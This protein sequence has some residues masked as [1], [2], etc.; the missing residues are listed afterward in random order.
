MAAHT[1]HTTHHTPQPLA[2]KSLAPIL[3]FAYNRPIHTKQTL[4]ALIQN[5]LAKESHLIIYSDAPKTSNHK[6][7]VQQV[8]RYL[9]DIQAQNTAKSLFLDITIIE[10]PYNFGLADSIIDGVSQVMRDFGK[11]IILEDDIVV[12][13]VFLD[14]MNASLERYSDNPKV[15]SI[16][17][18]G[19]PIDSS[20][21]G[22][23]Y[24]WRCPH[25]WGWASWSDRWQYFKRD[26][27]WVFDNFNAHDI[28]YINFDGVG[29]YWNDFLLNA[30]G[31]IK[32]WA[33]FNYLIAYKHNALTLT[34]NISYVKQI[35]FDGSG[36][37]CGEEG[38]V[39]NTPYINTKFPISYPD[40]I[41]ESTLALERVQ[42]FTKHL[43]K[44]FHIRVKNKLFRSLKALTG[45]GQA[46][47]ESSLEN[48]AFALNPKPTQQSHYFQTHHFTQPCN[49][50]PLT[51]SHHIYLK[52][53]S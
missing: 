38:N 24:F 23:C 5:P 14:Y 33:I 28:A 2:S 13:P 18:W 3:L 17:A 50:P 10:R 26:I 52:V 11:A 46:N 41:I 42:D 4:Q 48:L 49:N 6:E 15:W 53:A 40:K 12:S 45:G 30:Q 29:N 27:Q 22:D 1:P 25:C 21:L 9:Y 32:S 43:K 37:H 19:F 7:Q 8:R 51:H 35:G 20:G 44:P 16:S 39:F 34:P 47:L 31:K 36:V